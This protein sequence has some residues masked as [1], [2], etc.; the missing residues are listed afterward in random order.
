MRRSCGGG[1]EEV[2]RWRSDREMMGW[3]LVSGGELVVKQCR[4]SEEIVERW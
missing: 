4:G 1:W 2:E 3:W